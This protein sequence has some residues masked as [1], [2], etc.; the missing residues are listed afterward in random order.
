MGGGTKVVVIYAQKLVE[1]GH[2]VTLISLLPPKAP[3]VSR[4][5]SRIKGKG[6]A[7]PQITDIFPEARFLDH[8]RIEERRTVVDSDVPDGDVVIA[9]WWETAEWV[10]RL[11]PSKGTKVYFIQ[12]HEV[13]PYLPV[14]RCHE[15]YRMPLH[16]IVV[17]NWLKDV[18]RVSYGDEHVAVV[19]NGVD[20]SQ[21]F[22]VN[23]TKQKDGTVGILYST[24]PSKG[25]GV[26]Q[27]AIR[28]LARSLSNIR[29]VYFGSERPNK[30]TQLDEHAVF[31]H[32]P[33]QDKIREIYWACD[34]W[35]TASTS[36][37][38][39]LPAM[40]AMACGTPVVST[41][42][43]WPAESIAQHVNGV[44]TEIND[45]PALAAG[46]EWILTRSPSQWANLSRAACKTVESSSWHHSARLFEAALTDFANRPNPAS[47]DYEIHKSST[48]DSDRA[49]AT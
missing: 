34:A 44:L 8:R 38:F 33:P 30:S 20:H 42:A 26:S 31:H 4:L 32:L 19:P 40:E 9:T 23:R 6:S 12:H 46:L 1:F 39:N 17:A 28:L 47:R 27:A 11:S 41:R 21:F 7:W 14:E 45:V 25:L 49:D 16:K 5:T 24:T 10:N 29:V 18:M 2:R 36:E 48:F 13:F 22:A 43:G 15:T 37:G 35:L 3:L